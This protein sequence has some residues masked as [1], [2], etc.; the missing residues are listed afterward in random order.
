MAKHGASIRAASAR[1]AEELGF[2]RP[3]A[4][5]PLLERGRRRSVE[6]VVERT[7]VLNVVV[8]CAFKFPTARARTWLAREHVLDGLTA[9]ERKFL[10][11]IDGGAPPD[12][13]GVGLQTERLWVL[14]WALGYE[15]SL[16]FGVY[17]GNHLVKRLPDLLQ[18]ESRARFETGATLRGRDDLLAALDLAYCLTWGT[19]EAN[20]RGQPSPGAVRPYVLRERRSALE[21]LLGGDWDDPPMDT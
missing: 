19:T 18:D 21:W 14:C 1:I 6:S 20:L 8:A 12:T 17:C 10:D 4:H 15:A 3:P 11:A 7:I 16:D 2:L 9:A 5:L 13:S